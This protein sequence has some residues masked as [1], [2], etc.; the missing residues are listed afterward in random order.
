LTSNESIGA[1]QRDGSD[2]RVSQMLGNLEHKSVVGSLD[3]QGVEN[4]WKLALKLNV[5]DGTDNL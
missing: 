1:V 2:L 4:F 5:D 3:L